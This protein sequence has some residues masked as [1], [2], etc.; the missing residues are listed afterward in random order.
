MPC[1]PLSQLTPEDDEDH[2]HLQR[3]I[4]IAHAVVTSVDKHV[5]HDH[6]DQVRALAQ[7]EGGGPSLSLFLSPSALAAFA[8]PARSFPPPPSL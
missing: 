8:A 7:S 3:A 1:S 2:P 4:E 6:D 5:S